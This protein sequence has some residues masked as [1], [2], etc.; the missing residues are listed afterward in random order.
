MWLPSAHEIAWR[1]RPRTAG[2]YELRLH[3]NGTVLSKTVLVSDTVARRSPVRP[4]TGLVNKFLYPSEPPLPAGAGLSAVTIA[5]PE[6]HFI[7]AG[8]NIGWSGVYL[9]LTLVFAMLLKRPFN[10]VM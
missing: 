1:I 2:S 10:V 4:D 5:Y 9:V 6:R 3:V 7:V 8:R